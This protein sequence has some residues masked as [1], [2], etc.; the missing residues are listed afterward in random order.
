VSPEQLPAASPTVNSVER[1]LL[2]PGRRAEPSSIVA[3]RHHGDHRPRPCPIRARPQWCPARSPVRVSRQQR[4]SSPDSR[5]ARVQPRA[6]SHPSPPPRRQY[7]G[8]P[9]QECPAPMAASR[10]GAPARIPDPPASRRSSP[11]ARCPD[12]QIPPRSPTLSESPSSRW[13]PDSHD[14]WTLGEI[15]TK[16]E[17]GRTPPSTARRHTRPPTRVSQPMSTSSSLEPRPRSRNLRSAAN[18]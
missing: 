9:T 6:P 18:R 13:M 3:P 5:L 14:P 11:V 4:T 15:R 7:H 2:T 8:A 1:Q 12:Q 10:N 17:P 16:S